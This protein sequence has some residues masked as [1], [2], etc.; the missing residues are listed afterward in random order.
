MQGLGPFYTSSFNAISPVE[1]ANA[2]PTMQAPPTTLIRQTDHRM[3]F[4]G[5][6]NPGYI[7]Y[8]VFTLIPNP[9]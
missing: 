6:S 7:A 9:N 2:T 4:Y 3:R 5:V 8:T 1:S